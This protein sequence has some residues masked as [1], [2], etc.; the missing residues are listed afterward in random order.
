MS[1]VVT[2]EADAPDVEGERAGLSRGDH[3]ADLSDASR[4]EGRCA[5]N[6]AAPEAGA[7]RRERQANG[8]AN[9]ECWARS[10]P[11]SPSYRGRRRVRRLS[12]K[13]LSSPRTS[14]TQ[15]VAPGLPRGAGLD[16]TE[17]K[18]PLRFSETVPSK[19]ACPA[20]SCRNLLREMPPMTR[21]SM[22]FQASALAESLKSKSRRVLSGWITE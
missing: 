18:P 17:A 12:L 20:G 16:R 3:Q 1:H 6:V 14:I 13:C 15:K 4:V 5:W 10:S 21:S 19:T 9:P 2:F 7:E 8:P 22:A 11:S